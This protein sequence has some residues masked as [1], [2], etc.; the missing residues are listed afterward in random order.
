MFTLDLKFVNSNG[1][2]KSSIMMLIVIEM[3]RTMFGIC[4]N[5]NDKSANSRSNNSN[6]KKCAKQKNKRQ[7]S[8]RSASLH[9]EGPDSPL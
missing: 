3:A 5:S 6:T 4:N 9:L 7:I 1:N 2:S 8:R